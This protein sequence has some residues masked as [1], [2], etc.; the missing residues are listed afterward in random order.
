MCA[1]NFV[2]GDLLPVDELFEIGKNY[3]F[4]FYHGNKMGFQHLDC[5]VVSYDHPLVKVE[6]KGLF[7]II[8]CASS[9]F[10]E[11][12]SRNHREELEE[13]ELEKDS[14]QHPDPPTE[15]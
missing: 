5:Q 11:A 4:Y 12:I 8:N 2:K 10:I 13:L 15:N 1:K 3:V 7:R 6:T 14:V 9:S